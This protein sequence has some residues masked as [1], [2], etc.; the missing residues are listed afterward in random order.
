MSNDTLKTQSLTIDRLRPLLALMV[1]GLHVRPYYS[2][3]TESF[4]DGPYEA[5]VILIFRILFSVAVPFFFLISG[6]Y[7]FNGLDEWDSTV[8]KD[9]I[10]KRAGTVL[11]PYLLWNF[12]AL[13]C[14]PL[15]RL[16]GHLVNGAAFPDII[17]QI[18]ERGLLRLF[19]NRSL[20]GSLNHEVTTLFGWTAVTGAPM[21]APTLFLRDLMVV[22]L[23]SP[24]IWWLIRRLDKSFILI[25]GMLYLV[26]LWIPFSGFSSTAFFLFSLGA[27]LSLTGKDL[28]LVSRKKP[29]LQIAISV[30]TMIAAAI[31]LGKNAWI[32][33]ISSRLFIIFAIPTL[34][35]TV[36]VTPCCKKGEKLFN[37]LFKSSFFI[38]L[39]HTILITDA[40]CWIIDVALHPG[41]KIV[42]FILMVLCTLTVFLICHLIWLFMDRFT[43]RLL[44]ILTGNRSF[45]RKQQNNK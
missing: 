30:I 26:D 44:K 33:T 3:G 21:D 32:Y 18:N 11:V 1:V 27:W 23:F 14:Y 45:D 20:Y 34:F 9:K 22:I 7:F 37:G 31:S 17:A 12:I 39:I 35:Y 13:V 4:L 36:S 40:V 19:W 25:A 41:N 2:T 43:P 28:V 42:S 8:W 5:S 15:T 10:R 24:L 38:Y 16:A 29:V 6:L